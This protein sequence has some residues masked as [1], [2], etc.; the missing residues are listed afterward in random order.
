MGGK[1]WMQHSAADLALLPPATIG[2]LRCAR[3][4]AAVI[5]L[6]VAAPLLVPAAAGARNRASMAP[7]L[8]SADR[9]RPVIDSSYGSG[10]FGEWR[11]DQWGL[12]TY[13]YTDDE[14]TDPDAE[15]PDVGGSTSAE[16]QVGNDNIKGM[17]Y[18]DGY[19]EMWSQQLLAQW[20]N[21]Y[22]PGEEHYSGGYGYL[23]VGGHT[24]STLYLD[25]PTGEDFQRYFGVGYYRKQITFDGLGVREDTYAPF[26]NDPVLLDDV[27]IT[28]HSHTTKSA[29]WF[30]YW[31]VNPYDEGLHTNLGL[32]A[33]TWRSQS[34]TLE[35][36]QVPDIATD[37]QPLSSFAAALRGPR[38]TWET[39]LSKFFGN[40]TRAVPAEVA[41]NRLSE[42]VAP[43]DPLGTSGKT[44]FVLRSAVTL[45]PGRSIT[46]RYI[47][48]MA[49]PT[50]IAGLVAKYRAAADPEQTSERDW[51]SYLP[52][53]NFGPDYRWVSRE[54][55]WDGYLLRSATVYEE[56]SG[57]HTITQG[58]DY[59]YGLGANLGTRS[60]LH[61]SWPMAFSDPSLTRQ[62][63]LYASKLQ[64]TGVAANAQLPYGTTELYTPLELGTSNDLDFWVL[65][66]AAQYGL[67]TRDLSFFHQQ[68]PFYGTDQTA[69]EW[70]HLKIAFEHMQTY[71]NLFGE[72]LIGSTGDWNDFS[73]QFE[74]LTE[75]TL[76]LAQL[77]YAYP[78]LA[79]L[80]ENYGDP[81][82]AAQLRTAGA[83]D[84]QSLRAQ[85]VARGWY[86]RGY[87]GVLQVGTGVIFEEPQ[88]WAILAGAPTTT[89]ANQLVAN[90]HRYLDGYGA[91]GGPTEIG[92]AQV[93]GLNDPGVTEHGEPPIGE[94]E[95]SPSTVQGADEWPG[96]VWYDL[97]GWLTWAYGTLQGKVPGAV[98][99]A[100]SE[101]LRNTLAN[102]ATVFPDSW[103][104]VINV[105]DVCD[106]YYSKTPQDCGN[107]LDTS[108]GGQ[109][110]E[111]PTW[112]EMDPIDLAGVTPTESGY[113]I[114]PH[115][116]MTT[117]KLQ[118]PEV[119]VARA[120]KLLRGYV[121][122]SASG[123]LVMQVSEP[124]DSAGLHLEAYDGNRPVP[125]TISGGLVTFT[126]TTQAGHAA[127]WAVEARDGA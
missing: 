81:T 4:V 45:R 22:Q 97:N 60:W 40:G 96:G 103:D 74:H 110:T 77:A 64:P 88:P 37:T 17:A 14:M 19:V 106:A 86:S 76:I 114:T 32:S 107:D 55:E 41:A 56:R 28:N 66:A 94:I 102:H 12:P 69:T 108:F 47:Y 68:V 105:D 127:D 5:A 51:V 11:V 48:G 21:F 73:V 15:Q 52:R 100:W 33:P 13:H 104:G 93:P 65:E 63:L 126:I 54:I 87:S 50:E 27:T 59:Q 8:L 98:D 91:P 34:E 121:T 115:L 30:E 36:G 67:A 101:Y 83:Q 38:P 31:D 111:Q 95:Q 113:Q 1:T 58:G 116:P 53:V 46:L 72:Y 25:H 2:R 7:A 120:P 71:K 90:I 75:S 49:Q 92:T 117:F 123:K 99:D 57:E 3:A 9:S 82:F 85:W 112:M 42:T 44:L 39:S 16:N 26:G 24:A 35:V 70:Q 122:P 6:V 118:F 119:G 23:D 89:Q 29:S 125:F 78:Q 109:I 18:N 20:A 43:I 61:Y 62:I 10:R 80:A 124:P 79:Q 84:L